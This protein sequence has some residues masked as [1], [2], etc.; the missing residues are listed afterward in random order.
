MRRWPRASSD[1]KTRRAVEFRTIAFAAKSARFRGAWCSESACYYLITMREQKYSNH[2]R[3]F[4]LFHFVVMPLLLLNFLDHLVR[5]FTNIGTD[6]IE[7]DLL[8]GFWPDADPPGS[9]RSIDGTDR[10]EPSHSTRREL[11]Y[12]G[13]L[14]PE[15]SQRAS[16][17]SL[18]HI[19]ALR[20]AADEELAEFVERTLNG[21]FRS[22]RR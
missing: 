17:L 22:Q 3:W 10:A 4:P 18:S 9:F 12:A 15:L 19:I 20:F 2:T 1:S 11:R 7:R 16:D 5:I 21:E 6:R 14:S 8:D 13:L